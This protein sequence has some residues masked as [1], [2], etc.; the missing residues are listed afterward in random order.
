MNSLYFVNN[1]SAI[2]TMPVL[3]DEVTTYTQ[4]VKKVKELSINELF[5]HAIVNK[6][7]LSYIENKQVC[8]QPTVYSDKV[9]LLNYLVSPE[10][11]INLYESIV[12][13][14]INKYNETIFKYYRNLSESILNKYRI[15]FAKSDLTKYE[16]RKKLQ[17]F[18]SE[19]LIEYVRI[20]NQT[21]SEPI[22]LELDKDYRDL[23]THCDINEIVEYYSNLYISSTSLNQS[24]KDNIKQIF[25][26]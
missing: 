24:A 5:Q 7:Y 4:E 12:D 2:K 3:D 20:Y 18:T 9:T 6:F 22:E 25:Y 15:L 14:Y 1:P 16:L 8:V 23:K 10:S 17:E 26:K 19:Q 11:D 21:A 13:T